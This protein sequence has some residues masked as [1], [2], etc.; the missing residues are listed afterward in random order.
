LAPLGIEARDPDEFVLNLLDVAPGAIASLV[1][2]QARSLKHP[3]MSTAS[4][5]EIFLRQGLVRTAA[6]LREI[7]GSG[8]GP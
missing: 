1:A 8:G 3:P 5:L 4:L 6:R 2:E 7:M